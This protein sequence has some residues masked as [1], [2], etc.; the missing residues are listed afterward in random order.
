MKGI[1]KYACLI[2]TALAFLLTGCSSSQQAGNASGDI[3]N[4]AKQTV[5]TAVE[6]Q[7]GVERHPFLSI[8]SP[9]FRQALC[10][11]P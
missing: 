6:K 3:V 11:Y 1:M 9:I 8:P 5:T 4:K 2:L 10:R 7:R